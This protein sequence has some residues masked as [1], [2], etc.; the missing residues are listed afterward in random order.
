MKLFE[1]FI[2]PNRDHSQLLSEDAIE[3]TG[4]QVFTAKEAAF[5]GL[6]GIPDDPD[7]RERVFVACLPS[8]HSFVSSRLEAHEAVAQFRLIEIG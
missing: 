3:L 4:A 1:V 7:G 5:I 2:V 6:E 8:H